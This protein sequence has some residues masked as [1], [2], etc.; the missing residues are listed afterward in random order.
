VAVL[1]WALAA[2]CVLERRMKGL[3]DCTF[4]RHLWR[5]EIF[6][7]FFSFPKFDIM[8]IRAKTKNLGYGVI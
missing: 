5:V 1:T 2:S 8:I 4:N 7:F 3:L 6:V